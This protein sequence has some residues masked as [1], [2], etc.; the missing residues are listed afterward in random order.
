MF[1]TGNRDL[2]REPVWNRSMVGWLD[3]RD[4]SGSWFDTVSRAVQ[5]S[6]S[7]AGDLFKD[8]YQ[9]VSNGTQSAVAV[10]A[11]GSADAARVVEK[12]TVD[13]A[14]TVAR[15]TAN[16]AV[17]AVNATVN[18]ANKVADDTT[19]VAVTVGRSVQ[20][21]SQVVGKEIVKNGEIV[22][23]A[24]ANLAVDAWSMSKTNCGQIG[25]KVFSISVP[26][27]GVTTITSAVN[28]Y[29]GFIPESAEFKRATE[30]A[31]QC[32][33][34][35][36]DGFYCAFP[37]E[38]EKI[39]SQSATIPGNLINL[40]TRVFNEAKTQECLIADAATVQFG[41]IGMQ[42]CALGKVVVSDAKKAFACFTAAESKGLMKKFYAP[43]ASAGEKAN[44]TTFL[45]QAACTGIGELA[46]QVA[47][48][49]LTRGL[50]A[51]AKAAQAA[52]KSNTVAMVADQLRTVYKVAA[53]GAKYDD[54]MSD[55]EK[56]PECASSEWLKRVN[57]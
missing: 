8:G 39:V 42:V 45:N 51:E 37:A 17:I 35:T 6:M 7:G 15:E 30:G 47:E 12:A 55:L 27:Q 21:G 36:Q 13:T 33:E 54:I 23:Y 57:D 41:A 3:I 29:G 32:F 18:T 38:I 20:D 24:V 52:G 46:F 34:W 5:S 2:P 44:P 16:A 40:A 48:K 43:L 10:V 19:A 28:T 11:K 4:G 56:L 26:F 31:N 50:S 1:R 53:A 25:R 49:I 22:G 14:N 9:I